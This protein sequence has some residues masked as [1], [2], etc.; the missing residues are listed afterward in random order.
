[1]D[2][3]DKVHQWTEYSFLANVAGDTSVGTGGWR[4][5]RFQL[6]ALFGK[7]AA[8]L[9]EQRAFSLIEVLVAVGILGVIGTSVVMALDTNF[10]ATRTLDEHVMA[11][12]L[13]TEYLEAIRDIP[14]AATYPNAGENIDIP[15]QYGV[16]VNTDCSVDGITFGDCTGSDNET[17]QKI[18]VSVSR[19]VKP[20]LSICTYRCK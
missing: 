13:A 15:F 12:N 6:R 16:T 9:R 7:V 1:M 3:L 4:R 18:V 17:L 11:A 2:A 10:R 8:Y 19:E 14:Y 5:A 20:V